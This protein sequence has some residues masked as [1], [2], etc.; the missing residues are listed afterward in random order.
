MSCPSGIY[1][2]PISLPLP[3]DCPSCNLLCAVEFLYPSSTEKKVFYREQEIVLQN[4]AMNLPYF[5]VHSS[6]IDLKYNG[7]IYRLIQ[8]DL[9]IKNQHVLENGQQYD[10]ELHLIH[11]SPNKQKRVCVAVFG[12]SAYTFSYSQ[13]F[14]QELILPVYDRDATTPLS[15]S[16]EWN[17]YLIIPP[18]KSFYIYRGH[19]MYSPCLPESVTE[20]VWIIMEH[21][22]QIHTQEYN[23]LLHHKFPQPSPPLSTYSLQGRNLYYN[24]G[25][26]VS[27]NTLPGQVYIKCTKPKKGDNFSFITDDVSSTS[28]SI[29]D[30]P[31][32]PICYTNTLSSGSLLLYLFLSFSFLLLFVYYGEDSMNVL[33]MMVLLLVFLLYLSFSFTKI[34]KM[35]YLLLLSGFCVIYSYYCRIVFTALANKTY[36]WLLKFLL[37]AISSLLPLFLVLLIAMCIIALMMYDTRYLTTGLMK[38]TKLKLPID[39]TKVQ[40]S[41]KDTLTVTVNGKYTP[42]TNIDNLNKI[43]K[44]A[45]DMLEALNKE[46]FLSTI[47]SILSTRY[48][49]LT[50]KNNKILFS[51]HKRYFIELYFLGIRMVFGDCLISI[52]DLINTSDRFFLFFVIFSYLE[53]C[54]KGTPE[55]Q[56]FL[57]AVKDTVAYFYYLLRWSLEDATLFT[58]HFLQSNFKEQYPTLA[59]LVNMEAVSD[60]FQ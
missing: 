12:N 41:T 35:A 20:V 15:L 6:D 9:F 32:N 53:Y 24:N 18:T 22:I 48:T 4:Q 44:I 11:E 56:A 21:P 33:L 23:M 43:K 36:H 8:I 19:Q 42:Q 17:P 55:K 30:P 10:I 3:V 28:S 57:L 60:A 2:S 26:Y 45:N 34:K 27:G 31:T 13:S 16:K 39:V 25:E 1:H 50:I 58:D 7:D 52:Q 37:Y 14:F 38:F 59:Q 49:N 51:R 5:K 46:N 40:V 47:T 29:R 54:E